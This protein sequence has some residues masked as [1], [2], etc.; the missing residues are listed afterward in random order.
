MGYNGDRIQGAKPIEKCEKSQG[1][2]HREDYLKISQI[3]SNRLLYYST[4]MEDQQWPG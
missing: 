3:Y 2:Q 4:F 1:P